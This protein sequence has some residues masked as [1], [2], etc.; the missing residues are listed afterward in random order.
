M[1]FQIEYDH[2]PD[3]A[4]RGNSR[5]HWA[6]KLKPKKDLQVETMIKL[7]EV[8][9]MPMSKVKIRYIVYYCGRPIDA[10]NLIM[11]MK[12]A[13]DMLAIEGIIEDDNPYYVKEIAT[14]YHQVKTRKEVKLIMEVT[15]IED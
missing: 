4:L 8:G 10:D 12:H 1:K 2:M 3:K 13:Q 15:E 11:G 6:A 9:A 7:R 5:A 14:E